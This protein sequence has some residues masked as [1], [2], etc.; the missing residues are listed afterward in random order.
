MYDV[1]SLIDFFSAEKDI[2]YAQ[3]S[4]P[5]FSM[6]TLKVLE[7]LGSTCYPYAMGFAPSLPTSEMLAV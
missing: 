7:L 4:S 1:I 3:M 2:W 5:T 6:Y